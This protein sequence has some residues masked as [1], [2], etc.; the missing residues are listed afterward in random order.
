VFL[1]TVIIVR[2]QASVTWQK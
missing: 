2:T 1:T